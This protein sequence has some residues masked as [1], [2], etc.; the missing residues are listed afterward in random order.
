[1]ERTNDGLETFP[2][3]LERNYS[4][5]S[6]V[7]REKPKFSVCDKKPTAYRSSPFSS[8]AP[9]EEMLSYGLWPVDGYLLVDA[10][11]GRGGEIP[12]NMVSFPQF[13]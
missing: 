3:R 4:A 2:K 13:Y 7:G 1:M 11:Y 10:V 6:L 8:S 9:L 5:S 12:Q